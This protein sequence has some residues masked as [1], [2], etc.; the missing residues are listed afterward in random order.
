MKLFESNTPGSKVE[1]KTSAVVWHYRNVDPEYGDFKAKELAHTLWQSL[2]NLACE[3]SRGQMIVEVSSLQ[4]KKGLVVKHLLDTARDAGQPYS[5][6]LCVGD[7]RTDE[8][9]FQYAQEEGKR[10]QE[11]FV[12]VKVGKG[13]TYAD[14]TLKDP[15][16]VIRFLRLLLAEGDAGRGVAEHEE[17]LRVSP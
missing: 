10:F 8:T 2:A 17:L 12:S 13:Q 16:A 7:D 11:K 5:A 15:A 4:G 9:M 14:Y 3:V 1:V 6:V